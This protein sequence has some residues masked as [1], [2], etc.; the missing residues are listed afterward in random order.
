MADS[1]EADGASDDAAVAVK[2][3]PPKLIAQHDGMLRARS[4]LLGQKRAPEH[5]ADSQHIG[6]IHADFAGE[7]TLR[8]ASSREIEAVLRRPVPWCEPAERVS[9]A[10]PV[11]QVLRGN[12]D[13]F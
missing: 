10:L 6:E 1:V 13:L 9:L 8:L 4:A 11:E 12:P 5:R 7:N 2:A 3:P